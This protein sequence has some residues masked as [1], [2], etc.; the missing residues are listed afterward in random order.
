MHSEKK[1]VKKEHCIILDD[2]TEPIVQK[3]L[4]IVQIECNNHFYLFIC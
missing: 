4:K 3:L 1:D 2:W